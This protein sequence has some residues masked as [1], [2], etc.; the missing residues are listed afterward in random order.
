M[1]AILKKPSARKKIIFTYLIFSI[2]GMTALSVGLILP[3]VRDAHNFS[4]SFAGMLI[5]VHAVGYLTASFTAGLLP[6]YIGFKQS[7]LIFSSTL[8]FSFALLS[9]SNNQLIIILAFILTGLA[10][11]ST[12]NFCNIIINNLAPGVV[13]LISGMHSMF[14]IGALLLPLFLTFLTSINS[15]HWIYIVYFMMVMGL[16]S[17]SLYS[18][19]PLQNEKKQASKQ[20]NSFGFLK[21]PTF[22]LVTGTLFFYLCAEQGV[23]GWLVTYFRN[24]GLL[25][26]NIAQIMSSV[27][28]IA[29]LIGRLLTTYLSTLVAKGK[30]L[31]TM[32]FGLVIFFTILMFSSSTLWII[33]GILGFG[34]SMSGIYATT[35]SYAGKLIRDY[36][37]TWSVILTFASLGNILMPSIIG[38]VADFAG[39]VAGIS[40]IIFALVLALVFIIALIIYTKKQIKSEHI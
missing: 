11:G 10:R 21:N 28:W 27:L 19:L 38:A 24:T 33:I 20:D 14:A 32:G 17:F 26:G 4:Y 35:V 7:C 40:S 39:I 1:S 22:Y 34:L 16:L 13:W 25:T 5:S 3:F 18:V 36:S 23:I 15:D 6:K 30:L 29:I 12:S 2:N 37:M 9:A 31:L 8:F